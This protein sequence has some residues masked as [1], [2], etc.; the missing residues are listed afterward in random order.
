MVP[1]MADVI[2]SLLIEANP[3]ISDEDINRLM[4]K[5]FDYLWGN[6]V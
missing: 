6:D 5:Y 4:I 2:R 1:T 3:T